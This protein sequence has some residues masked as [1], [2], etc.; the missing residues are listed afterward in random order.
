MTNEVGLGFLRKRRGLRDLAGHF[1]GLW[2]G[3]LDCAVVAC[4]HSVVS[5]G[6]AALVVVARV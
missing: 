6:A 5:V 2:C 4:L 1:G 3:L